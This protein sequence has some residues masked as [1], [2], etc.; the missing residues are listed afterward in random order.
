METDR[1]GNDERSCL[2]GGRTAACTE[3]DRSRDEAGGNGADAGRPPSSLHRRPRSMGMPEGLDPSRPTAAGRCPDGSPL[4]LWYGGRPYIRKGRSPYYSRT[5][6]RGGRS[7]T[8]L[9]HRRIYEDHHGPIPVDL[10]HVV[11]HDN[12]DKTDNRSE[13]LVLVTRKQHAI[14]HPHPKP[15]GSGLQKGTKR[16]DITPNS[17]QQCGEPTKRPRFCSKRCWGQWQR[18]HAPTVGL[19]SC[20]MCGSYFTRSTNSTAVTCSRPCRDRLAWERR[21]AGDGPD[22]RWGAR[23]LR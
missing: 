14:E 21:R 16:S 1:E 6:K 17:C 9:L 22:D 8:E 20:V 15:I 18:E 13:N 4:I 5:T 10:V 12:H 19:R 2:D 7:S 11:H 23:L 3:S